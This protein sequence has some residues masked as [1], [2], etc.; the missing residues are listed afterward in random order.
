[1]SDDQV[2][3]LQ[4]EVKTLKEEIKAIKETQAKTEQVSQEV[5]AKESKKKMDELK[6]KHNY[7]WMLF[8]FVQNGGGLVLDTDPSWV[9][10]TI[11]DD[12]IAR[13][14]KVVWTRTPYWAW[15]GNVER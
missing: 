6:R 11:N 15:Q 1:M 10:D 3:A 14:L 4:N 8:P 5:S 12:L 2:C 9:K 7:H 13:G